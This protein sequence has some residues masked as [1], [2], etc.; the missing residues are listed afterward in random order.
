MRIAFS[1]MFRPEVHKTDAV[2]R[3]DNSSPCLSSRRH[4]H[5]SDDGRREVWEGGR[6]SL[7]FTDQIDEIYA[8][9]STWLVAGRQ[10]DAI[11]TQPNLSFLREW[12]IAAPGGL[13]EALGST[14]PWPNLYMEGTSNISQRRS[15]PATRDQPP[16]Y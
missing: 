13:K 11:E 5:T 8:S 12:F 16:N 15:D 6:G 3:A 14:S 1:E 2:L 9:R 10:D 4:T 7:D